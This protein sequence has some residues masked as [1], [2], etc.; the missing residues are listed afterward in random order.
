MEG[1]GLP[2]SNFHQIHDEFLELKRAYGIRQTNDETIAIVKAV[3]A[4]M[5]ETAQKIESLLDV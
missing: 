5:G 4:E 3:W 2:G 1:G